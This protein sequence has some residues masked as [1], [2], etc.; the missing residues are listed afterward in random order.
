[1]RGTL[2]LPWP[3]ACCLVLLL[4]LSVLLLPVCGPMVCSH[5]CCPDHEPHCTVSADL[6]NACPVQAQ[7]K[8]A[9]TSPQNQ[10]IAAPLIF[11]VHAWSATN[12]HASAMVSTQAVPLARGASMPLRI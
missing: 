9:A 6:A 1:M 4:G 11:A 5:P 8:T 10:Q 3:A 2:K 7:A 12:P